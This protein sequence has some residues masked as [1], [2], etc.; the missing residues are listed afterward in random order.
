MLKF[1]CPDKFVKIVRQIHDGM[2]ACVLDDGNASDLFQVS[3]WSETRLR[4]CPYAV[5]S[6]VLGDADRPVFKETL[7]APMATPL[8]T[9][10]CNGNLFN[11]RRLQATTKVKKTVIHDLLF[12]DKVLCPQYAIN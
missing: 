12:A 9:A 3:K 7:V 5:H 6:D 2:M 11:F 8:S 4:P 1:G 10:R